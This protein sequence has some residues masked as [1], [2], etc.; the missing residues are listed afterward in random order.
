MTCIS[1]QFEKYFQRENIP[2]EASQDDEDIPQFGY[3][4]TIKIDN[5]DWEFDIETHDT[6]NYAFGRAI[7][8]T[9]VAH[10]RRSAVGDFIQRLNSTISENNV[11]NH[12]EGIGTSS[13]GI[14]LE[15]GETNFQMSILF[16]SG[17]VPEERV[18]SFLSV[19]FQTFIDFM[20]D[21]IA[22]SAGNEEPLKYF[23][24]MMY[25]ITESD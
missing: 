20:P 2:G 12:G 15:D 18:I 11:I 5:V 7:S 13:F 23:D 24:S 25:G 4:I 1:K 6:L 22:F 16:G 3:L 9:N 8:P 10:H 17:K 19:H 21:L 14:N